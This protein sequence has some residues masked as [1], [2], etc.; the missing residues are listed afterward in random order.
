MPAF[1]Q[2]NDSIDSYTTIFV[3]EPMP[4]FPGGMV[5]MSKFFKKYIRYPKNVKRISGNIYVGFVVNEDGLLS[6][7]EIVRGLDEPYDQITLEAMKKML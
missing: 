1:G 3:T 5:E 6:E 2:E 7:F 4:D